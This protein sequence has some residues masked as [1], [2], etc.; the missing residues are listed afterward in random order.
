MYARS[1]ENKVFLQL[2]GFTG[3]YKGPVNLKGVV[4][5]PFGKGKFI[6]FTV[7]AYS[8]LISKPNEQI[9]CDNCHL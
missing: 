8:K 5:D 7:V 9:Y 1:R 2:S 3:H 6:Q 4:L